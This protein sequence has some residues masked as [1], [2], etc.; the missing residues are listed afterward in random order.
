MTGRWM[1]SDE[2]RAVRR[3]AAR[4]YLAKAREFHGAARDS[5]A[6]GKPNAAGLAAIHT[7]ISAADAALVASAGVRSASRDH[8]AVLTLLHQL[9]PEA[10][11]AQERQLRGILALKNE[12]AYEQRLVAKEEA[13]TLVENAGRLVKWAQTVVSA[14][15]D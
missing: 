15:L 12:I 14:H 4:P 5:L 8:S 10:G 9:V 3:S 11:S 1:K 7:G 2:T 13:R 6:A